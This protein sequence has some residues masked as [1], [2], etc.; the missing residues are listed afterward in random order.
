MPFELKLALKYLRAGRKSLARFTTIAAIVGI[1]AGVASLIIAQAL[2]RGFSDEMRDKI[3]ANT[4]HI[5]ISMTD[6]GEIFAWKNIKNELGKYENIKEIAP[7]T[8]QNSIIIGKDATS[9]AILRIVQNQRE[10]QISDF[11]SQNKDQKLKTEDQ[12]TISIGAELAKNTGLKK[13]DEANIIIVDN[14]EISGKIKV[15][16]AEIFQT[17]LYEY[18]S[19]WINISPENYLKLTKTLSFIPTILNVSVKDIYLTNKNAEMIRAKLGKNYKILD[20]QKA[21]EPLF[22]ALSLERKVSLAIISLIIFVA[23]LNI[24]TTLSLLVGQRK[25]DIAVLRVCG[26]KTRSLI[27]VFLIEG[28]FIGLTGII[29]GLIFGLLGCLFGNYFKIVSLTAEVYSLNYIPFHPTF[30]NILLIICIAFILCLVATAYP[31]FKASKIKPS[32]N[33]LVR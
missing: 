3:L 17:G 1:A 21:N 13:Y 10:F 6:G 22:A 11:K 4:P 16:V 31:A 27:L 18:D 5:S 23:V 14:N 15:V 2:A 32:E 25:L 12:F 29:F 8:Y 20:W 30:T 19:T 28:L 26:V 7:M 9:Y 24:T 33:L